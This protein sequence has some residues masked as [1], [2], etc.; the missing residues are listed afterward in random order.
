LINILLE[1]YG[2]KDIAFKDEVLL[3][4][5]LLD[6][7]RTNAYINFIKD[8]VKDKVVIE[9]GSGTGFF[10]WLSVK[11]GAKKV[12]SCE[13]SIELCE[14]LNKRFK[15]IDNLEVIHTDIFVDILP[16]GDIY[17]HKIFDCCALGE[18]LLHF[19]KNCERQNIKNIYPNNL[20]LVSC[21]LD[22]LKYSVVS[23]DDF[24]T[25]EF[26]NDLIEFFKINNKKLDP[27]G[28]LFNSDYNII[29]SNLMFEGNI[30]NL[31]N[32]ES[33]ADR[34]YLYTYFEAGFNNN[35]YSSFAKHQNHWKLEYQK[36]DEYIKFK[37]AFVKL[38]VIDYKRHERRL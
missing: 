37:R 19:L 16:K 34:K 32:L 33:N 15:N 27:N 24:D 21:N 1:K 18:G 35:Y 25:S 38:D 6:S 10:S 4:E 17:I 29:E 26:D 8:N 22:N 2:I 28:R 13:Q 11:Y 9:C 12:Y 30:F 5:L 7:N 20:R 36:T 23:L 31:L 3:W 14:N